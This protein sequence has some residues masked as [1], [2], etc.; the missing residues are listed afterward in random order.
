MTNFNATSITTAI[1]AL[2]TTVVLFVWALLDKKS[3]PYSW[4]A[5]IWTL[6][7]FVVFVVLWTMAADGYQA[8]DI[9]FMSN[10][11]PGVILGSL[12]CLL[13][14]GINEIRTHLK[15]GSYGKHS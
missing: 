7:I 6:A 12:I 5:S 14:V 8:C 9:L 3:R 4:L 11:V 1:V 2:I 15:G 10:A 13:V